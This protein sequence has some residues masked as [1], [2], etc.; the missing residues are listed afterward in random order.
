MKIALLILLGLALLAS[1][2]YIAGMLLPREHEASVSEVISAPADQLFARIDDVTAYPAWRTGTK[3]VRKVGE[4]NGTERFEE[5]SGFGPMQYDVIA[6]EAPQRR[7]TRIVDGG[8]FGGTWTFELKAGSNG[9]TVTITERGYIDSPLFRLAGRLVFGYGHT[10]RGYLAD[11]KRAATVPQGN[12][13][14]A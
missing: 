8:G 9:T 5:I 2:F 4:E 3:T 14:P 13:K 11:L 12:T 10:I 6:R 7:V 1:T